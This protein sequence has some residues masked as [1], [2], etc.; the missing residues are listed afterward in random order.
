MRKV[1]SS[2]HLLA[3]PTLSFLI[4]TT[5]S[6]HAQTIVSPSNTGVNWFTAETQGGGMVS[7]VSGPAKPPLGCGSLQ[8]S[9]TNSTDKAQYLSS[10]YIGTRLST[11]TAVS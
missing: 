8:L 7:F 9:L 1:L 2:K 6:L 3:L 11:I 4:L 10:G 5:I